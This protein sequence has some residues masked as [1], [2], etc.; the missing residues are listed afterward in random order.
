MPNRL[1]KGSLRIGER[2][3]GSVISLPMMKYKG[4]PGPTVFIGAGI[5]GD[6]LTGMASLWKLQDYL[7]GK[8]IHGEITILPRMN[9][10][11]FNFNVRGIP[12]TGVDLNR[13]F[14]GNR[15]GFVSE[16]LTAKIWE[17]AKKHDYIVDLH[18]MGWGIPLVLVDPLKGEIKR[19]TDDIADSTGITVLDELPP[20]EYA[21]EN[22]GSSFGAVAAQK[23]IPSITIELGGAKAIDLDT[24]D[25]G[26]LAMRNFLAHI[27]VI[28]APAT[29]VTSCMVIRERGYRRK[30]IYCAKG[31][32]VEYLVKP[33]NRCK[34][35]STIARIRGHFGEVAEEV[36]MPEDGFVVALNSWST[37]HTG[38]YVATIAVRMKD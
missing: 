37:M 35:G 22:L 32:L 31:G 36:K 11:G 34:K 9:P 29:K 7:E 13:L 33:G 17:V 6:E 28:D 5:H 18:T 2:A 14:P 20:E 15:E 24:V 25:A 26:Y 1:T 23:G 4:G 16:R 19:R 12:E 27:R 38:N 30:I 21:L 8:Q 3:D 10:D